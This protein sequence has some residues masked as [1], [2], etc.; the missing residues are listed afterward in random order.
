MSGNMSGKCPECPVMSGKVS[1]M[2]VTAQCLM[3]DDRTLSTMRPRVRL[4]MADGGDTVLADA[5]ASWARTR[6]PDLP[7]HTEGQELSQQTRVVVRRPSTE[8]AYSVDGPV[9]VVR[10]RQAETLDDRHPSRDPAKDGVL[11]V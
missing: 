4:A 5:R 3:S 6:S 7:K 9:V 8:D 1:G 10:A 2:S 11:A